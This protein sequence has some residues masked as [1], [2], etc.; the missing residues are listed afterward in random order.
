MNVLTNLNRRSFRMGDCGRN[1]FRLNA[2]EHK[3]MLASI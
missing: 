1:D 2:R 3:N